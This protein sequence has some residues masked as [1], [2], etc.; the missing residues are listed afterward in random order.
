M[1]KKRL[2]EI[3]RSFVYYSLVLA[4]NTYY[5]FINLTKESF[6]STDFLFLCFFDVQSHS[7][8]FYAKIGTSGVYRIVPFIK[9]N[10]KTKKAIIRQ[11]A[12]THIVTKFP[13]N[14]KCF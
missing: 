5:V 9:A 14:I 10:N 8:S 6:V 3:P 4:C 11:I 2:N 7:E 13:K 1:K 12:G